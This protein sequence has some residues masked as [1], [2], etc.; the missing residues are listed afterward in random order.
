MHHRINPNYTDAIV[1]LASV[2]A[3]LNHK[4][5][6]RDIITRALETGPSGA[7]ALSNIAVVMANLGKYTWQCLPCIDQGDVCNVLVAVM[8]KE[9][10][11]CLFVC[12]VVYDVQW[13]L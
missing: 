6:A 13:N 12:Y 1:S 2:L 3:E 10:C 5:E 11:G 7:D 8:A 9:L 4:Q